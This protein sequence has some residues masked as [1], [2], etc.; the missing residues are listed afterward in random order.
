[1]TITPTPLPDLLLL[2]PHPHRDRRGWFMETFHADW[3]AEHVAPVHFVQDNCSVS[4][5]GVLRGLHYQLPHP[6]GK[7][8][9]AVQ[10]EIFDVAVDMRRSS[11]T[12]GQWFGTVLSARNRRRLW[13]PAGFAHGFYTLSRQARCHYRCTAYYRPEAQH[14]IAWNDP[15]LAV[16]WQLST[17]PP[18]LSPN[19]A[20]GLPFAAAPRFP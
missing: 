14:T 11:P 3:F 9:E 2:Q 12:F 7:L 15:D 6:Q 18:L 20:A 1:M 13:L 19:D 5:R 17:T 10:G 16:D 4:R 8:I